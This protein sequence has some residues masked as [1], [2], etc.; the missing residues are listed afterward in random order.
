[1]FNFINHNRID[2]E[3]IQ[4]N[5]HKTGETIRNLLLI[6]I[7]VLTLSG[8]TAC[9]G[10]GGSTTAP[11]EDTTSST[12]S[13]GGST[14][15]TDTVDEPDIMGPITYTPATAT[16]GDTVIMHIPIDG[17]TAYVGVEL[18]G[19]SSTTVVGTSVEKLNDYPGYTT[20]PSLGEQTID[21]SLT[22]DPISGAGNYSPTINLCTVDLNACKK[23]TGSGGVAVNY[24]SSSISASF[25]LQRYKYFEGGAEIPPSFDNLPVNSCVDTPVLSV[26]L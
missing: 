12:T 19:M 7:S 5:N 9:G 13:S 20:V 15:C 21:I 6:G 22:I 8:L 3:S 2:C 1:M 14:S 11:I 18:T 16:V 10:G 26:G 4:L 23:L 24:A 25:P 17:I